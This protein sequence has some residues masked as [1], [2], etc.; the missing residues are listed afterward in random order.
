MLSLNDI[1]LLLCNTKN[2]V[3]RHGLIICD[4]FGLVLKS[5]AYCLW[6]VQLNYAISHICNCTLMSLV[7]W[8]DADTNKYSKTY[9]KIA[10]LRTHKK[11]RSSLFILWGST[12]KFV[13]Y[14]VDCNTLFRIRR[15]N[16]NQVICKAI[17]KYGSMR[18]D[19][20]LKVHNMPVGPWL[21]VSTSL[22]GFKYL[23]GKVR[24]MLFLAQL[25][26]SSIY[27]MYYYMINASS[28]R[29]S[30]LTWIPGVWL[31]MWSPSKS[32]IL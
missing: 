14:F 2:E 4:G 1:W 18:T 5:L 19:K 27:M 11:H 10:Y 21:H 3:W 23:L 16:L 7:L 30:Y 29:N 12:F 17:C 15:Y 31:S 28:E 13:W 8:S 9:R 24:H 20:H 25:V 6:M 22:N 26:W 32:T